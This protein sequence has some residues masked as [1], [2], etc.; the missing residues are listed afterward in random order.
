MEK[1]TG[2]GNRRALG[3]ESALSICPH[4]DI[5][6]VSMPQVKQIGRFLEGVGINC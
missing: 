5:D 3:E 2:G 6:S 4:A 1:T